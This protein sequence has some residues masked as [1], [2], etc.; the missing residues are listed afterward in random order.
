[1]VG[2][3]TSGRRRV[4][5]NICCSRARDR[6]ERRDRRRDVAPPTRPS[7]AAGE[8][9]R[10]ARSSARRR[11]S[12][13]SATPSG[14]DRVAHAILFV[15]PRGT[16]KTSLARILAKARQLHEPRSD[17]DPCD[18][19]PSCVAIREGR[20]LDLVE[21]DAAS[22]RGIDDI[23][24][25]RERINYAADRPAP[26]GL[27]PRRGPPDH[28]GRLERAPQVA[29]GAARLRRLHVRLHPSPGVPAGDPVAPPAVR[30]PAPDRSPEIEGKLQRILEAD[31]R[32]AEPRPST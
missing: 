22:N 4:H 23:R 24:D 6:Q 30:R 20:A 21:I 18:A 15:G 9:R 28:E 14:P 10:S 25:L 8:P 19:C 2:A 17:G 5:G 27:H 12:R 29:R 26:Q 31:G 11:S 32:A 3:G 16:G 1:M 13:R 7:T